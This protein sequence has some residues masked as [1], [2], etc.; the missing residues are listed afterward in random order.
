M[1]HRT[2]LLSGRAASWLLGLALLLAGLPAFAQPDP[3]G[4][5]G[6]LND[7]QGTVSFSPA[8]TDD[9]FEL[10]PNR[11]ITTGDRLWI[12]RNARAELSLGAT[13]LRL[14]E[15]T[16]ITLSELDDV[17]ARITA[18]QGRLQLRVREDLAGQRI[19]VDTA[20]LAMVIDSPGD[21]RIETDPA[22][23]TTRVAVAAG[24]V[25]LFGEG[26]ES[27]ALGAQ[28]QLTTTGRNLE[29]V[30]GAPVRAGTGFDRW[31]AERDRIEDQSISARYVSRDVV[32]Y[33]QLD[34]YGDWQNDP[35][36]GSVWYPRNV[37]ADWAPY[38][39]G[40]WVE[41]APWGWTWIDAAPWGF[42]PAHY[43]RWA[44]IGP[45]WGWVPGPRQARPVY[46]PALV[47]FVGGAAGA[48]LAIGNGRHGVGWF[49]LAPG[50]PWRP[51]YRA[52]QRYVD[53]A[54]R[55]AFQR[56]L[57]ARNG[58]F[59]NQQLPGAVTVVPTDAFGRGPIGRRDM[60]R[61]PPAQLTGVPVGMGAP[62]P[63]GDRGHGG[64]GRPATPPPPQAAL[65]LRQFQQLQQA[66][67]MQQTP[68]FQQAPQL[69]QQQQ[70]RAAQA[71][72]QAQQMQ[73]AQQL[74]QQQAQQAQRQQIEA[75][76]RAAQA[77]AQAQAQQQQQ[78]QAQRLQQAQ[79]L[80]QQ[81]ALQMQQAQQA[82]RQQI[83]AQQRAVQAQAQ[84][85]AQAQ[86]Q[87]M[88]LQQEA[89]Q[90]AAQAQAQQLQAMQQIQAQRAQQQMQAQQQMLQ[91]QQ[92]QQANAMRQAQ[93]V[94]QRAQQM[95][96]Q[97]RAPGEPRGP[98]RSGVP[99]QQQPQPD[100]P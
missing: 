97:P 22:A 39:D 32:G 15:Q 29:A 79:Q 49:P 14:D 61:L 55:A 72:V 20:N 44:R 92:A 38:R 43:G 40:Q 93:E 35:G 60:V 13:A 47:G 1:M 78:Q 52:S 76:Q 45:R 27:V 53:E 87:A 2:P 67:Q 17:T 8:G 56:Q 42:A 91:A 66:Q 21:Y 50:E 4:R 95:Q 62:V 74:Q 25:T 24:Q 33:Q 88:H 94:Q 6:R 80:Q 48:N 83:E 19:E 71:Q 96:Q 68:Q 89:Q 99:G 73:Q 85:Q 51:G 84:A 3:P 9:W 77:Q 75:Q 54:N 100:R 46:A 10:G 82:Q 59:A 58:G 28:Q 70:Q 12:D 26:G 65:Q 98:Q 7:Q 23:G 18:A 57:A 90:R 37:D 63:T 69:Q 30:S 64:F 16:A 34:A 5:V 11:P 81:Q 41:V 31:V 36:Y 86:Q